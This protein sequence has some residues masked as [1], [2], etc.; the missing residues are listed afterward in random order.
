MPARWG[1]YPGHPD[2]DIQSGRGVVGNTLMLPDPE[3]TIISAPFR[4]RPAPVWFATQPGM[5]PAFRALSA[6]EAAP[7]IPKL[8]GLIRSALRHR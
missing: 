5:L 3:K 7:T 4:T 1:G 6:F 8:A 2:T